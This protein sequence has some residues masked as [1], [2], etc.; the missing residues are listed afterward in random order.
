MRNRLVIFLVLMFN[1]SCRVYKTE[2][3]YFFSDSS[4]LQP[5]I[6]KI[7]IPKQGLINRQ[8]IFSTSHI[9]REVN[10]LYKDSSFF[11]I[12]TNIPTLGH[13]SEDK[14]GI[15]EKNLFWR[16]FSNDKIIIGYK[17]IERGR[18]GEFD[19]IIESTV[20]KLVDL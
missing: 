3:I 4:K 17:N 10:Y 15:N 16:N 18:K 20:K 9:D 11:Y 14:F 5:S 12:N 2:K 1:I 6:I 13:I 8:D 19:K 7:K